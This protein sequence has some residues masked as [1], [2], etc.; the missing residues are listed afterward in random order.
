[1]TT[2]VRYPCS[3]REHS[4]SRKTGVSYARLHTANPS[5]VK[6]GTWK[7]YFPVRSLHF[8]AFVYNTQGIRY[9]LFLIGYMHIE[10]YMS[11]ISKGLCQVLK[12]IREDTVLALES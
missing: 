3:T 2:F 12:K 6:I 10:I 7:S 1:M 4:E 5:Q 11:K 8:G 9:Y